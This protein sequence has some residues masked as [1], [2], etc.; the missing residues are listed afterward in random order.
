MPDRPPFHTAIQEILDS[1]I[2]DAR[3]V[4]LDLWSLVHLLSGL[5]LGLVFAGRI[6]AVWALAWAV[7][8]LLAYEV[9]E[10]ALND[11]LFVPE[12]PV[13]VIWDLIVGFA[14]VFIVLRI[15]AVK[16]KKRARFEE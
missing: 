3:F 11:V 10:L 16:K 6:R 5:L 9:V 12:T 15:A 14:G 1:T 4:Y 8:I 2:V 7:A 13:D